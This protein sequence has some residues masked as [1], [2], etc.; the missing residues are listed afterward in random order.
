MRI[1]KTMRDVRAIAKNPDVDAVNAYDFRSAQEVEVFLQEMQDQVD[2][3]VVPNQNVFSEVEKQ[4]HALFASA[5]VVATRT[6]VLAAPIGSDGVF[7][8][9]R[10]APPTAVGPRKTTPITRS[11]EYVQLDDDFG[12][13][14]TKK[15]QDQFGVIGELHRK[16]EVLDAMELTVKQAFAG[17]RNTLGSQIT[18]TRAAVAAKLK[19]ALAFVSKA[20]VK[21]EP[22]QF[23]EVV[24]PTVKVL[25]D[26]AEG[27]YKKPAEVK[28]YLFVKTDRAGN[29][30]FVFQRYVILNNFASDDEAFTYPQYVVV[31]TAMVSNDK[32]MTMHVTTLHQ[33]RPPGTF[34][35]GSS[36]VNEKTALQELDALLDMDKMVDLMSRAT[37]PKTGLDKTKFQ[38]SKQYI[39]D[40][41]VDPATRHVRIKL[42]KKVP[43]NPALRQR[44]IEKLF[45][46]LRVALGYGAGQ[47]IKYKQVHQADKSLVLDFVV[48]PNSSG[49]GRPSL[50]DR[51]RQLLETHFGF[52]EDDIHSLVRVMQR[53]F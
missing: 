33:A 5:Q 28:N 29:L 31:F 14:N 34:K 23:T 51:Q 10:S 22:R 18:K 4:V 24:D 36:F 48:V 19:A 26:R 13:K 12:V 52:D 17:E 7:R 37:L 38:N 46:D 42:S 27:K 3:T 15:L 30:F 21:K 16:M 20:A 1:L 40:I 9:N 11:G 47:S 6:P 25:L 2:R 49:R 41:Q 32:K 44:I 50:T 45:L 39:Q 53:G 43:Q 8:V 35:V